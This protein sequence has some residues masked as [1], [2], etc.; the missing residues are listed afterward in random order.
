[1][2][3]EAA[4]FFAVAG[5]AIAG[6]IVCGYYG[7]RAKARERLAALWAA[8]QQQTA[9]LDRGAEAMGSGWNEQANV[10]SQ[11]KG[12]IGPE[13]FHLRPRPD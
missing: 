10:V 1:M 4:C 13:A 12:V 11:A 9:S 3:I 6:G 8:T 5:I 7:G 2:P